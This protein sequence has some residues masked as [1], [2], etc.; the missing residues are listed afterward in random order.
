MLH[1]SHGD[2]SGL[3]CTAACFLFARRRSFISVLAYVS[4]LLRHRFLAGVPTGGSETGPK[5]G[6]KLSGSQRAHAEGSSVA[7][8]AKANVT[9]SIGAIGLVACTGGQGRAFCLAVSVKV[10]GAMKGEKNATKCLASCGAHC[11][12]LDDYPCGSPAQCLSTDCA[13]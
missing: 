5:P 1:V 13:V 8:E 11:V 4:L 7:G 3:P 2:L 10:L 6:A 9:S 12:H